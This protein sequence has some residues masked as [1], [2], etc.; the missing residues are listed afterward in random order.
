MLFSLIGRFGRVII[1]SKDGDENLL[2]RAVFEELRQLDEIIQNMTITY[3]GEIYT[4]KDLC[5]RWEGDCYINDILNLDKIIDDV[6]TG[7]LS[8]TWPIMFNPVTWDAHTFPVYFGGTKVA[9]DNTIVSVPSLHLVYFVTVDT[10]RQDARGAA[11]EDRFLEV[12]GHYEDTGYFKH[13]AV[14]R[15]SSRTL[16]QELEKNTKT[17][18]PYF[19]STFILITLFR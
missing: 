4:Y 2:R 9:D 13:I 19:G 18:V 7:N 15:F 6:E 5:A 3:E 8:L 17:V 14:A 12:M 16:D 1:I 10:P 11:W